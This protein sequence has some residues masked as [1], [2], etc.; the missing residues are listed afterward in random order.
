LDAKF[1]EGK[2]RRKEKCCGHLDAKFHEEKNVK[3]SDTLNNAKF[4][5]KR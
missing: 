5:R 1:P 3:N 4:Q 2:K